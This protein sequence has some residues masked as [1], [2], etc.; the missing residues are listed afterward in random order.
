M[1]WYQYPLAI[2]DSGLTDFV[3]LLTGGSLLVALGVIYP[4]CGFVT[5]KSSLL[6]V[7]TLTSTNCLCKAYQKV[8]VALCAIIGI[9]HMMRICDTLVDFY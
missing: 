1:L 8:M 4:F 2:S 9:D 3:S 5:S 6:F 7:S